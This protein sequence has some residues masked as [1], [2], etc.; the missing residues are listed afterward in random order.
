MSTDIVMEEEQGNTSQ[1]LTEKK[2]SSK[3]RKSIATEPTGDSTENTTTEPASKKKEKKN[4]GKQDATTTEDADNETTSKKK[5]SKQTTNN[6]TENDADQ[7]VNLDAL[8]PIAHPLADK[9]LSKRVLRTVKKGSN[10]NKN[11]YAL[12]RSSTWIPDL[13]VPLRFLSSKGSKQRRIKRGVKEVVKALRKGE[14]GLVVMAGDISPMDV[15]THIPLLAEE[16]GS[17]YI[18]VPTKESLGAASSTKRP[19]SCVMISTS[20]GGSEAMQK[21]FAEKKKALIAADPTKAAKIQ[22][23]ED[24]YTTSFDAVLGEVLRLVSILLFTRFKS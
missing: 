20:R 15:L 17:G 12:P 2:T 1:H 8:S 22:A 18:F 6:D 5:K 23:D 10:P 21:K 19:T 4:K 14:K 3:K 11:S 9:K 24:E 16:N 7:N 13:S